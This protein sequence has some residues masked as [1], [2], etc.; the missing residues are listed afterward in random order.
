MVS[1]PTCP[2]WTLDTILIG[3]VAGCITCKAKRLK[4]DET[5]PS[6]EQCHKRSV[7]CGGYKKDFKWRPFEETSFTNKSTPSM[8]V[9]K[10]KVELLFR[11]ECMFDI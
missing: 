3:A 4:C 11:T 7:H 5:K 6:C 10:G 1:S 9:K 2:L 8:K